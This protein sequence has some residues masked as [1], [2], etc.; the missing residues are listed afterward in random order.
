MVGEIGGRT[1]LLCV[2]FLNDTATTEIYT[3]SL[4]D[5]LPIYSPLPGRYG[6]YFG[7]RQTQG[8]SWLRHQTALVRGK[9]LQERQRRRV[10]GVI[11]LE[12]GANE[13]W[14]LLGSHSFQIHHGAGVERAGIGR[15]R[16]NPSQTDS[17][18]P[19]LL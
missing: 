7:T 10:I 6:A 14:R 9:P 16:D 11:D 2:F 15:F 8:G 1:R 4:H 13:T 3:L 12:A 5:A 19:G 17:S 18:T